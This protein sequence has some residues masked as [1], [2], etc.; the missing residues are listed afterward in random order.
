M[1]IELHQVAGKLSTFGYNWGKYQYTDASNLNTKTLEYLKFK[2]DR[3]KF[4]VNLH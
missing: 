3:N 1:S 4:D 2:T